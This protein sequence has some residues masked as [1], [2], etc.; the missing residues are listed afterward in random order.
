MRHLVIIPS[1]NEETNIG[2]LLTSLVRQTQKINTILV[3]NDGSSDSTQGVVEEFVQQHPNVKLVNRDLSMKRDVG[4]KIIQAFNAGLANVSLDDYDFISKFD[5][6]LEFEPDYMKHVTDAF[7]SDEHL[8]LVGGVCTIFSKGEWN[9]E[10]LTNLDHVR[11]ALKTYRTS[12]FKNINGLDLTMGWDSLDEYKL[13][14]NGYKVLCIPELHVK[15]HRES[16]H[17]IGWFKA[18]KKNGV[19]L[20]RLRY[21][22]LLAL[23]TSFKRG[24]KFK[25]YILSGL[26]LFYYYCAALLGKNKPYVTH[27]LGRFIR[28]YRFNQI[29][30]NYFS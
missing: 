1:Y 14:M 17:E 26:V 29:K 20:Y 16:N 8:G 3:V 23:L 6:D 4:A 12:A 11:G 24:I 5:A 9:V 7:Y 21:G 13:R 18:S 25:P 2:R 22:V 19:L 30:R 10:S 27:E 15:H 28:G